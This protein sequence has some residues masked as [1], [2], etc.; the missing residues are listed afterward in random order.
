M[1]V[2]QL[3]VSRPQPTRTGRGIRHIRQYSTQ[4][5]A[6]NDDNRGNAVE[7]TTEFPF[8]RRTWMMTRTPLTE[9]CGEKTGLIGLN[10]Y[11]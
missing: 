8:H 6:Q 10:S 11:Q 5:T 4:H 3:L 9:E 1:Y 2:L 7:T